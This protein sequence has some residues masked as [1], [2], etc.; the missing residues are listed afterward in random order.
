MAMDRWA[1][2]VEDFLEGDAVQR[3][4]KKAMALAQKRYNAKY[5]I[6]SKEDIKRIK[7]LLKKEN[8]TEAYI[9]GGYNSE[10]FQQ[11]YL[12]ALK[13]VR[14]ET[15]DNMEYRREIENQRHL[16]DL[17]EQDRRLDDDIFRAEKRQANIA[18]NRYNHELFGVNSVDKEWIEHSKRR[19][20]SLNDDFTDFSINNIVDFYEKVAEA[21]NISDT[22]TMKKIIDQALETKSIDASK[23][24]P[25]I[26]DADKRSQ[27]QQI[28]TQNNGNIALQDFAN[29]I[30]QISTSRAKQA[31]AYMD[32]AKKDIQTRADGISSKSAVSEEIANSTNNSLTDFVRQSTERDEIF[33]DAR[34]RSY[35][36]QKKRISMRRATLQALKSGVTETEVM[37]AKNRQTNDKVIEGEQEHE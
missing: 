23:F 20:R 19:M 34:N 30:T 5:G 29:L 12:Q 27:F 4:E 6:S 25:L 28:A 22:N 21:Y 1:E 11:I 36:R 35:A 13:E 31:D 3:A 32:V 14:Q 24:S 8:K 37:Y 10:A 26:A 7:E 33:L 9:S 2:Q 17:T 15:I 16:D 18:D